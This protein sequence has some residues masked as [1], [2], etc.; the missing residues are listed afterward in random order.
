[1]ERV[2][3][4]TRVLRGRDFRRKCENR[5][6]SEK[7]VKFDSRRLHHST[8][9]L[10]SL[11][12]GALSERMDA[13]ESK[14]TKAPIFCVYIR[15]PVTLAYSESYAVRSDARR[16]ESQLTRWTTAKKEALVGGRSAGLHSLA[17]R[18]P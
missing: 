15:R 3:S 11:A 10:R 2:F 4:G 16:R 7:R 17:R 9:S 1:M 6:V 5:P 18:H 12:H 13:G 14:G 8:R